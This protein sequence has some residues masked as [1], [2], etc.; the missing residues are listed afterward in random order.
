MRR[1]PGSKS[2]SEKAMRGNKLNSK[3]QPRHVTLHTS[4]FLPT[5]EYWTPLG[6]RL[7]SRSRHA[8]GGS[9]LFGDNEMTRR[10]TSRQ[11][12][13]IFLSALAGSAEAM[14]PEATSK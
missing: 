6:P 8:K 5:L 3:R 13:G 11:D 12:F 2:A 7:V 9:N 10:S 1:E 4:P 14:A